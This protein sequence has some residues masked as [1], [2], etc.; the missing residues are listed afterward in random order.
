M[1]EATLLQGTAT[2]AFLEQVLQRA[3][4]GVDETVWVRIRPRHIEIL[5]PAEPLDSADLT[6]AKFS[7]EERAL[8]L[9]IVRKLYGIWSDEDEG[10]FQALRQE[11]WSRWQAR[12]LE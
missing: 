12:D 2:P 7:A 9:S 3:G 1:E 6:P 4:L 8:R 5:G 10:S 11:I